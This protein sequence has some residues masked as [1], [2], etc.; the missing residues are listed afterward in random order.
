MEK[1]IDTYVKDVNYNIKMLNNIHT[2]VD[3]Y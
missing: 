1:T 3:T 2:L